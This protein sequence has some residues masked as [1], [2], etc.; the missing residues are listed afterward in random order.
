MRSIL[1]RFHDVKVF[2]WP[3]VTRTVERS[4]KQRNKSETEFHFE[5][6]CFQSKAVA[7]SISSDVGV[8]KYTGGV[9]QIK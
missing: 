6:A 5:F 2:D 1:N 8:K 3:Y 9:S 7:K 4:A